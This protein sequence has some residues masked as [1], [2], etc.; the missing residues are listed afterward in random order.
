[1]ALITCFECKKQYSDT[2]PDCPHCGAYREDTSPQAILTTNAELI[3]IAKIKQ[4]T[5]ETLAK[6]Q[7]LL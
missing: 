2:R 4:Y 1:M 3:E 5:Q 7:T 6:L